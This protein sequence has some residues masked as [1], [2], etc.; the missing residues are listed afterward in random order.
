M[1]RNAR[2]LSKKLNYVGH[3]LD[4]DTKICMCVSLR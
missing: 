1:V 2:E 3:T 4:R